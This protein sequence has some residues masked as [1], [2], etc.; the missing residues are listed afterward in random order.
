MVKGLVRKHE[1]KGAF[2]P[3]VQMSFRTQSGETFSQRHQNTI[4]FGELF[5]VFDWGVYAEEQK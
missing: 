4:N 3:V 2:I 1:C 5:K